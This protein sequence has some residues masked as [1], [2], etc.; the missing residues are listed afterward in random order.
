MRK[1]KVGRPKE[2]V[3]RSRINI[4]VLPD[5]HKKIESAVDPADKSKASMGKVV[6]AKFEDS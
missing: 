3:R 2:T 4:Y 5:T 6:D 1:R